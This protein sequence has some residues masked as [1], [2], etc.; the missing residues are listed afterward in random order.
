[1]IDSYDFGQIVID[2]QAYHADIIIYPDRVDA[3]WWRKEGHSLCVEDIKEITAA[4]PEVLII[5]C[6]ASGMLTVPGQTKD[7][8]E[9]LGI[10]LIALPTQAACQSYNELYRQKRVVAGMHLTC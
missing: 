4:K 7:Y 9:S 3:G 2:G 10:R 8:L 5:G 6:G 1:M